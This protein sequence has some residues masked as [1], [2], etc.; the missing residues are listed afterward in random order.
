M[1]TP[2]VVVEMRPRIRSCSFFVK[3]I[4]NPT[5]VNILDSHTVIINDGG[6]DVRIIV[7]N[8]KL[9]SDSVAIISTSNECLHFQVRF[10]PEVVYGSYHCE[11]LVP[12]C[13]TKENN[14]LSRMY[15]PG[16]KGKTLLK[17][18]CRLCLSSLHPGEIFFERV[19]PLPSSDCSDFF[20]HKD[21][22]LA[23]NLKPNKGDLLYKNFYFTIDSQNLLKSQNEKIIFCNNCS[24]WLGT[25]SNLSA[26][27][28]N[29]T[30][31]FIIEADHNSNNNVLTQARQDFLSLTKSLISQYPGVT[32]RIILYCRI[33]DTTV[34]YLLLW[35]L[36]KS[37]DL[38]VNDGISDAN[39]SITLKEIQVAKVLYVYENNLSETVK[40]WKK[41][42]RIIEEQISKQMMS[43]GLCTLKDMSN[44]IPEDF[45]VT[46][47]YN[48]SYI[49]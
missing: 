14:L 20:C 31:T 41:D 10:N 37:L 5:S 8:I 43:E 6:Q 7:K 1:G 26:T 15:E 22:E 2:R 38:L 9:T 36:E 4:N 24:S 29:S 42:S 12:D 44:M 45:R 17:I 39:D 21:K 18:C 3:P 30:V 47:I 40:E 19:L 13:Q 35:I 33:D 28:W 34:Q 23:I 46:E 49:K 32:C 48:V 16:V 27:L 25:K 11:V